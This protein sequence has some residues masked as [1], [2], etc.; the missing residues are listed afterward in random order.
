MVSRDR[1]AMQVPESISEPLIAILTD[2]SR[3]IGLT[4]SLCPECSAEG[5]YTNM[6]LDSLIYE[7]SGKIWQVKRCAVHG[8]TK[9]VYWEDSSMYAKA[10]RYLFKGIKIE[11]PNFTDKGACPTKC[12]LCDEHLSHTALGNIVVTNRCNLACCYCFFYHKEGENVYEPSM[13]QL[14]GMLRNMKR[15]RPVGANVVQFT[16]GEPTL[17]NDLTDIIRAA[18]E[19]DYQHIMLNTNGVRI[20]QDLELAKKIVEAGSANGGNLI[21]YMSFD[22]VMRQ[23][24]PKN[25]WEIPKA[26]ENC[27]KAK[28]NAVLVP[29][30]IRDKRPSGWRYSEVRCV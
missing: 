10:S 5:N 29:T 30:I 14:R 20:S 18:K 25:Y 9:E 23:T 26:L 8:I 3:V 7:E 22:G 21:L 12:G 2:D 13:E 15:T 17:R 6:I 11:N 27:R 16:G 19:E 24:N 1:K 4:K 28:L